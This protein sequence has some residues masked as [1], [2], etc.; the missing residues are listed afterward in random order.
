MRTTNGNQNISVLQ[1]KH[2]YLNCIWSPPPPREE[3]KP[4]SALKSERR[5]ALSRAKRFRDGGHVWNIPHQLSQCSRFPARPMP[6]AVG[7]RRLPALLFLCAREGDGFMMQMKVDWKPPPGSCSWP[8]APLFS[9]LRAG[10]SWLENV[11]IFTTAA[12]GDY[13]KAPL[14]LQRSP[15]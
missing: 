11:F 15:A 1:Q 14:S 13:D 12:L 8:P 2:A 10:I 7:L 6:I 3:R 4:F 5:T 9:P